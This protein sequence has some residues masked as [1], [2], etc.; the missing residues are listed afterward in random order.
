MFWACPVDADISAC[1]PLPSPV[2]QLRTAKVNKN[3]I[4]SQGQNGT[5]FLNSDTRFG[6]RIL[7]NVEKHTQVIFP[8]TIWG[9]PK[10]WVK[11]NQLSLAI[12]GRIGCAST[13]KNL[14]VENCTEIHHGT[15][16]DCS[17][18]LLLPNCPLGCLPSETLPISIHET[19]RSVEEGD[20]DAEERP[21]L[22]VSVFETVFISI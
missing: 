16:R 15:L 7:E 10:F 12:G 19:P 8:T 1:C 18:A 21:L 4:N 22:L 3:K 13:T 17:V 5:E 14:L 9:W 20:T 11:K 6:L 2:V